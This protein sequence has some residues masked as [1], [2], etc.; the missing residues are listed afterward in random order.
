ML[1]PSKTIETFSGNLELVFHF[2]CFLNASKYRAKDILD[3]DAT[4][5]CLHAVALSTNEN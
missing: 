2:T 1:Q 5:E 3:L 4:L